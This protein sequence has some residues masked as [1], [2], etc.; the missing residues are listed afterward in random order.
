MVSV[1]WVQVGAGGWAGGA[2][3]RWAP[4]RTLL[5]TQDGCSREVWGAG[6]VQLGV[7]CSQMGENA[8]LR[9]QKRITAIMSACL[10]LDLGGL[11]RDGLAIMN[12]YWTVSAMS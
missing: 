4:K 5:C 10:T 7:P 2:H 11:D 12:P 8:V 3:T 1:L 9:V 6:W